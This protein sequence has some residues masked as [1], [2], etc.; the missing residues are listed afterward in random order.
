MDVDGPFLFRPP[1]RIPDARFQSI[2]DGRCRSSSIC[3]LSVGKGGRRQPAG[4]HE[5][6]HISGG[7][8]GEERGDGG[9]PVWHETVGMIS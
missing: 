5:E 6:C 7:S 1:I 4:G 8:L 3:N 9:K 2:L